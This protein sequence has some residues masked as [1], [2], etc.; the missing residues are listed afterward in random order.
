MA[1]GFRHSS[2]LKWTVAVLCLLVIIQTAYF[3]RW[4]VSSEQRA[5]VLSPERR[6]AG[7]G[8]LVPSLLFVGGGGDSLVATD[9]KSVQSHT[10]QRTTPERTKATAPRPP[11]FEI[12][13]TPSEGKTTR[14]PENISPSTSTS[15]QHIPTQ[16][17]DP[18]GKTWK[19]GTFCDSYVE[20]TFQTPAPVCGPQQEAE[21]NIKC[22]RNSESKVMVYCILESVFLPGPRTKSGSKKLDVGLL[23]GAGRSCPTITLSAIHRT[24]ERNS[25][26]HTLLDRVAEIEKKPSSVCGEWFNKTA[27]LYLADQNVHIYFRMNAYYNLHKAI[28]REGVAPG[29]FVIIKHPISSAYLFSEWEKMKLF[30]EMIDITDLPNKTLCFRKLVIVPYSFSGI[31]FRCKMEANVRGPCFN[32]KGRGLYGSSFYSFRHRVISSCGLV[33]ME[34]H[35]GNSIMLVSRTPY[36]RWRKDEP[37]KFQRVLSNEGDLVQALKEEF[38]NTNVTVAHMEKL[39]ICDQIQLAHDANVLMG[40]HGAGLVHLWWLQEDALI[41]ELNPTFQLGNPSFKMLSTLAGR[42]YD[43]VTVTGSQHMVKVKVDD[44]MKLLKSRTH[45][46]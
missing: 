11:T 20:N 23:T 8:R 38:P 21:H 35:T 30:P 12:H 6:R 39:D 26:G 14:G 44:V 43:S 36:K 40:V 18:E 9:S 2:L 29:D 46:S 16:Y 5:S 10:H 34:E 28:A 17:F 22:Y 7:S 27:F 19:K 25:Q 13:T 33:D 32:C 37:K 41:L 31:P 42:N 4:Y 3:L 15:R 1:D 45:L 24:S